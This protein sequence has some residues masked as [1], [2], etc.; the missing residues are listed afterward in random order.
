MEIYAGKLPSNVLRTVPGGFEALISGCGTSPTQLVSLKEG[1]GY[2]AS[3]KNM[4]RLSYELSAAKDSREGS[5]ERKRARTETAG[6]ESKISGSQSKETELNKFEYL[7]AERCAEVAS[8]HIESVAVARCAGVDLVAFGTQDG[9][10]HVSK[11]ESSRSSTIVA[12]VGY[13]YDPSSISLLKDTSWHGLCF[14]A[15]VGASRIASV[16]E[17]TRRVSV[18]DVKG[19]QIVWSKRSAFSPTSVAFSSFSSRKDLKGD[20]AAAGGEAKCVL[21][22]ASDMLSVYDIREKPG[23]TS[24]KRIVP[25]RGDQLCDVAT[26]GT[27][28]LVGGSRGVVYHY[29]SRT[30]TMINMW[31]APVKYSV[32]KV[33]SSLRGD[34]TTYAIGND[35]ELMCSGPSVGVIPTAAPGKKNSLGNKLRLNHSTGMRVSSRWLGASVVPTSTDAAGDSIIGVCEMGQFYCV[36]HA[37]GLS[38]TLNLGK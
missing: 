15:V 34:G 10:V 2:L 18:V 13:A 21:T 33:M 28:V 26:S 37:E 11:S 38:P 14:D 19:E 5:P 29:D 9:A 27:S 12:N 35:Y 4:Y 36:R 30:W 22:T 7:R 1:T 20:A 25:F 6:S 16:H 23:S 8:S 24:T 3:G 17:S 31:R 32:L